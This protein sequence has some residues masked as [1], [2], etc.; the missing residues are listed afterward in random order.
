[1]TT[2]DTLTNKTLTSPTINTAAIVGGTVNNA[3][4][5][6]TTPTTGKFTTLTVTGNVQFSGASGG[7]VA[8]ALCTDSSGNVVPN[9][10]AN[11]YAGGSAGAGGSNTQV[12]YNSSG[13]LAGIG[14]MT[15]DG[16]SV[17]SLGVAGSSVGAIKLN[18]ATSGYAEILPPTGAL[19]T[20]VWTLQAATD[21]FVG[22]ATT[23]TL[24]NKSI[25]GSEI[26]SGTIGGTYGGTGVNNGASTIT[27]AGSLV[28]TGAYTSTFAASGAYTYTMPGATSTLAAIGVAQTWTAIQKVTNSDI[29]LLGSSTGCTTLTSA[30][31]GASNYTLTLPAVTDT[32]ATL[33]TASQ[34]MSGGVH[35]SPYSIGTV[36]GGTTTIDCGNNPAQYLTNGGAFTL[37]APANDSSCLVLVTNNGSAGAITFSGFTVGANT[38]DALDTTNGHVFTLSI[39]R[40]NGTA[41]YVIKA[42]Q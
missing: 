24:T 10:S 31:A 34:A 4:I 8:Y 5:G 3:T 40:I 39:W 29:C 35:L 6:A 15:F 12:Q 13:V 1:L 20:S 30:N 23:D 21:T 14:G 18:N 16:A 32:L 17:L 22:R 9:S 27:L 38:G 26:N 33:G 42:L 41:S 2:S 36:S 37:A 7:S 28:T 25:A 11:C 19:G